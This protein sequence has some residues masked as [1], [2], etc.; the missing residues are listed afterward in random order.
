MNIHQTS[1][2]HGRMAK[3]AA[4]ASG[5]VV[6]IAA[7]PAAPASAFE[8]EYPGGMNSTEFSYCLPP[9]R[10]SL[11]NQAR[12]SMDEAYA[13]TLSLYGHRNDGT[14]ANAFQHSYWLA[15]MTQRMS[16]NTATSMGFGNRH[17]ADTSGDPK[18]MDLHNN[19]IGANAGTTTNENEA[20]FYL[21]LGADD[22]FF[23]AGYPNSAP[24]NKLWY[25]VK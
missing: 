8:W 24:S 18:K 1:R 4:S 13:W 16:N 15:R 9:S 6:S 23:W 5:V 22:A 2:R 7:L 10:W 20:R 11:C 25:M 3:V 14:K 19:G 21:K 12:V 17:E